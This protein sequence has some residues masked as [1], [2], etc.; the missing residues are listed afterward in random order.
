M[1]Q[2][3]ASYHTL[4]DKGIY[5][6]FAPDRNYGATATEDCKTRRL[7]R[8]H[9]RDNNVRKLATGHWKQSCQ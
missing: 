7:L 1:R 9:R 4:P 6:Q 2:T 8:A 3:P 5:V